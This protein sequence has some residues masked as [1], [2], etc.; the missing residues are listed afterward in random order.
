M[1]WTDR[2]FK[3]NVASDLAERVNET[4]ANYPMEARGG[5]LFFVIMME[6]I[7]SQ[8]EEAVIALQSRLKRMDLKTIQGEHVDRAISLCRA[9]LTRLETFGKVPDDIV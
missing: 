1:A 7:L 2:F 3:N 6:M 9:A 8:T 5:P 4:Y